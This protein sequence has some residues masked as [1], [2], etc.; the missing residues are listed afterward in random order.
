LQGAWLFEIGELAAMKKF[1][2]EEI[3]Q[4]LSKTEDRYRVAYDR[5]V[6]EFPRKCVFFG[7]TNNHNFLQDPTGNRRFWPVDINPANK[8]LNHWEKLTDNVV[9]LIWAE[10]LSLYRDGET[11][12]L[13]SEAAKEAERMQGLHLEEDPREGLIIKYLETPLP[14]DWE[15]KEVW[16]RRQYLEE[17]NGDIPRTRVC[18]AEIWSEAL[19]MDPAK[20]G[21]WEARPIYDILRKLP[22]WRERKEGRIRFKIYGRQTAYYKVEQ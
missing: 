3:K 1:E 20:F 5:Q 15:E 14:E 17:P 9:G 16:A 18:A 8:K 19:G 2:I 6:S 7:T 22:D 21:A 10:A 13:D 12:E 4:F 11:L